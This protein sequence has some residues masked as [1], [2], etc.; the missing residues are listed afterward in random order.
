MIKKVIPFCTL[1]SEQDV[2]SW[3]FDIRY[4][5]FNKW[6]KDRVEHEWI[7]RMDYIQNYINS[8]FNLEKVFVI[9]YSKPYSQGQ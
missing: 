4:K 6:S 3:A 8:N 1:K 9:P 2:E 7:K 5:T